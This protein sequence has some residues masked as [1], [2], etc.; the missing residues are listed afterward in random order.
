LGGT[1]WDSLPSNNCSGWK[2]KICKL[3]NKAIL[4]VV[5]IMGF[6][7]DI[8]GDINVQNKGDINVDGSK[9]MG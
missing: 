1:E 8:D 4:P 2:W 6:N 9:P 5:C 7:G 3:T